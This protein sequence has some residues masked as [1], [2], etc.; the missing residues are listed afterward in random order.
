VTTPKPSHARFCTPVPPDRLRTV[1][2]IRRLCLHRLCGGGGALHSGAL[3]LV[4]L[5]DFPRHTRPGAL[6]VAVIAAACVVRF[7][8][9]LGGQPCAK[10]A[11]WDNDHDRRPVSD[12]G[13]M[14]RRLAIVVA[15]RGAARPE[16]SVAGRWVG[17]RKSCFAGPEP[18]GG[19]SLR[20]AGRSRWRGKAGA[21]GR[22]S[23]L[24]LNFHSVLC[25]TV[26]GGAKFGGAL[27]QP[28]V[29]LADGTRPIWHEFRVN[30]RHHCQ[31]FGNCLGLAIPM[32]RMDHCVAW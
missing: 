9:G 27:P 8:G 11:L 3:A 23:I 17:G 4:P 18:C 31:H 21:A 13:S 28:F 25:I 10:R 19:H 7:H 22:P 20:V 26:H 5:F 6:P 1:Q 24:S 15:A 14:R 12:L 32:R 30:V 2:S 16:R 29:C